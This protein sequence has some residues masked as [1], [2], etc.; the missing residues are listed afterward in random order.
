M[1]HVPGMIA[2]ADATGPLGLVVPLRD[3][4]EAAGTGFTDA[5]TNTSAFR[6]PRD[7]DE[8]WEQGDKGRSL[9]ELREWTPYLNAEPRQFWFNGKHIWFGDTALPEV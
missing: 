1:R 2:L 4:R 6:L 8:H 9:S 3:V 5:F 7:I